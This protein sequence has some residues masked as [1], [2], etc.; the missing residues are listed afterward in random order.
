MECRQSSS[1]D[2]QWCLDHDIKP[3]TFYNWANRLRKKGCCDIPVPSGRSYKDTRRKCAVSRNRSSLAVGRTGTI[4]TTS[5]TENPS[6][7]RIIKCRESPYLLDLQALLWYTK[8]NK[9]IK[10]LLKMNSDNQVIQLQG[11]IKELKIR[12]ESI[13]KR[14]IT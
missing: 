6:Q 3:G 12:T 8:S 5:R 14:L 9:N 7:N 13:R 4:P 11:R 10:E 2:Q 1:A